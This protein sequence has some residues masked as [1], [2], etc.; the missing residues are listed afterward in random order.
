MVSLGEK[1]DIWL[2]LP[3]DTPEQELW[4][5]NY[6]DNELIPLAQE[7]FCEV[8]AGM[9]LPETYGLFVLMGASWEKA[10][11][12][13]RL[14]GPQSIHVICYP[15]DLPQFHQLMRNLAWD[16]E[17]CLCTRVNRGDAAAIYRV[18]KKQ[19]DIWDSVGTTAI[20]YSGGSRS[21]M[22]AAAQ[23]A[24]AMQLDGYAITSRYAETQRRH[25][26]GTEKLL[27][28]PSVTSVL[29]DLA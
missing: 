21:M 1:N 16:D 3:T 13:V 17:R 27:Q 6:Y 22:L 15:Q 24:G 29:P 4:A 8:H 14:R 10:A 9:S 26:P 12:V 23:A 11:F 7:Q 28:F 19:Y 2:G 18:M 5:E 20:D 25:I